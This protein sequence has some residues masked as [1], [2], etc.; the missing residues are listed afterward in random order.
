VTTRLSEV[1]AEAPT[2]DVDRMT[3]AQALELLVARS[4]ASDLDPASAL[5]W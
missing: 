1:A 2:I 3:A 5:N 4:G